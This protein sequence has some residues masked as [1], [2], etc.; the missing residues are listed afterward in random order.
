MTPQKRRRPGLVPAVS[1][2]TPALPCHVL[3]SFGCAATVRRLT[4]KSDFHVDKGDF[5]IKVTSAALV[6]ADFVV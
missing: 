3:A 1:P 2:G 6:A 5:E 4:Q